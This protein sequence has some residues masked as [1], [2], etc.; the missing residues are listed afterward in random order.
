MLRPVLVQTA[1]SSLVTTRTR[2]AWWA[3]LFLSALVLYAS[4]FALPAVESQQFPRAPAAAGARA[5][6]AVGQQA[7]V[8]FCREGGRGWREG[9]MHD[10]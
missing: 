5:V 1:P 6:G 4:L 7:A 8:I 2:A 3:A 10:A 9:L